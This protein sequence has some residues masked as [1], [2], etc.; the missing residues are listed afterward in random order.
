LFLHILGIFSLLIAGH[1]F[2]AFLFYFF[3]RFIFHGKLGKLPVL[4]RIKK[5]HSM[6]HARP[7]DL[8]KLFF[9]NWSKVLIAGIMIVL[10]SISLPFAV[11][12]CSFFPV[13]TYR[14]WEAH[15][16]SEADW[17]KHHMYHHK[18]NPKVNF[19]GIYPVLDAV[20]KTNISA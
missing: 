8:E 17:A 12:L 9:P 16:E 10:G 7:E 20:F 6:H 11:G 18:V 14:H 5:I 2:G 13:Y 1:C 3:H 19:G 4:K 15:H